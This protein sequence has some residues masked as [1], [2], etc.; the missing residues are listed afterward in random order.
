MSNDFIDRVRK[1]E[2]ERE[3]FSLLKEIRD[4]LKLILVKLG[5][6]SGK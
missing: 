5:G 1:E 2:K 4:L 6:Q 3:L